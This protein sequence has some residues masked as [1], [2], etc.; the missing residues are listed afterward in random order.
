MPRQNYKIP[1]P[2]PEK[3]RK[4]R[5]KRREKK[6]KPNALLDFTFSIPMGEDLPL[7]AFPSHPSLHFSFHISLFACL[8]LRSR[9]FPL[10]F[11]FSLFLSHLPFY[12]SYQTSL[13]VSFS[14]F[15][16]DQQSKRIPIQ[17]IK[18]SVQALYFFPFFTSPK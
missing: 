3:E 18:L 9:I 7:P 2:I 14:V 4:K 10:S 8:S 12:R 15:D 5:N 11:S 16:H 17:K 6:R 1:I 13:S